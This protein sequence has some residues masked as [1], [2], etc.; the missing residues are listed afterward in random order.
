MIDVLILLISN[1]LCSFLCGVSS[2]VESSAVKLSS[3][4]DLPDQ[5]QELYQKGFVLAAFHPFIQ[6]IDGQKK[7]PPAKMFRAILIKASVR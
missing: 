6:S 3:I 1:P 4:R 7:T 2:D 5:L